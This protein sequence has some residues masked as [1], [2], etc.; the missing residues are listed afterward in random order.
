[1]A[2][3]GFHSADQLVHDMPVWKIGH[4]NGK[5]HSIALYKDKGGRKIS[6]AGTDGSDEGKKALGNIMTT[7]LKKRRAKLEVSKKALDFIKKQT[8]IKDHALSYEEAKKYHK[9]NG[10]HEISKPT[11]D[12][13][14]VQRHPDLKDHF[15]VRH[16]GGHPHTKIMLGK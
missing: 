2:L 15:Y 6:L 9:E 7:D 8:N 13:P 16:I 4:K 10:G 3:G 5:I 11:E 14:E 12:D 1:M